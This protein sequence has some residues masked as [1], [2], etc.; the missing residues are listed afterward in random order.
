MEPH[1]PSL[2]GVVSELSNVPW[3]KAPGRRGGLQ[4]RK[5]EQAPVS[6]PAARGWAGVTPAPLLTCR[7]SNKTL[8]Q[9]IDSLPKGPRGSLLE[10]EVRPTCNSAGWGHPAPPGAHP[11]ESKSFLLYLQEDGT[12]AK[13]SRDLGSTSPPLPS[14]TSLPG[15]PMLAFHIS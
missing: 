4:P 6:G 9:K 12:K 15:E 10:T 14:S 8:R 2:K 1:E 5:P 13:G 11:R 3:V 7:N